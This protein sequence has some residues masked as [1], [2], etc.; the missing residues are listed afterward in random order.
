MRLANIV[1]VVMGASLGL[2]AVSAL[3]QLAIPGAIDAGPPQE[4]QNIQ[5]AGLFDFLFGGSQQGPGAQL[6][7]SSSQPPR[8]DDESPSLEMWHSR[9]AN[10]YRTLCVRLCDGFYFPISF[11]TTRSKFRDDAGRCERQCPSGSRLFVHSN[12]GE[13]VDAMVDL[14][15]EAYATLPNAFRFRASYVADCTCRGNPWDAE[16][17]ARH[18]AYARA[19]PPT[20]GALATNERPRLTEPRRRSGQTYGY[21]AD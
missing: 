12:P 7:P 21:R 17:L 6:P 5:V 13:L 20:T 9:N 18:Q 15:G 3:A 4:H 14:N 11:A 8:G 2:T 1:V 16:A 19:Q 10:T